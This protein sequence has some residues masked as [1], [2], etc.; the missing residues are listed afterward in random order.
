MVATPDELLD[1][2]LGQ[3]LL[4]FVGDL[5]GLISRN[6]LEHV[7]L[8]AQLDAG[9]VGKFLDFVEFRGRAGGLAL[10]EAGGAALLHGAGEREPSLAAQGGY[11]GIQG[12]PGLLLVG[13]SHLR[14]VPRADAAET[15]M[16]NRQASCQPGLRSPNSIHR[17]LLIQLY[18]AFRP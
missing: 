4:A 6:N 15:M 12:R 3:L 10:V 8:L 7:P 17:L 1:L 14:P 9:L 16:S 2:V 11:H 18:K 13:G 5:P